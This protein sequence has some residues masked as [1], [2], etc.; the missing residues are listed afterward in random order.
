MSQNRVG[1]QKFA[2]NTVKVAHPVFRQPLYYV[3]DK[4]TPPAR[5]IRVL[6][7]E[8]TRLIAAGEVIS[9][10][11]DVVRELLDNALDAGALKIDIE[12]ERG[13]LGKITV[14]DNGAGIPFDEVKLAPE[15]HA[16]SKLEDVNRVSTL[17]FRGEALW[18]MALAGTLELISRPQKQLG[19]AKL[20]AKGEEITLE[21]ISAPAGT[22][23]SVLE[24]FA[25]YPARREMQAS[26][27]AEYREVVALV[28]RYIL[29]YPNLFW[30]LECDGEIRLQHA[31]SDSRGAVVTVYGTLVGNRMLSL[32]EGKSRF[33][34]PTPSLPISPSPPSL[35]GVISRP[36]LSRPH[37][38]RMHL[39]VNR[40]PVSFPVELERAVLSAY[41]ELLSPGHAPVCVLA[42]ELPPERVNPNVHPSKAQV[43]LA[44]MSELATLLETTI[45]AAL[46]EHPLARPAPELRPVEPMI[47]KNHSSFPDLEPLA[48]YRDLYLLAEGEG[49][50]WLIDVHAAHERNLYEQFEA[51]FQ[52]SESV[53]LE[54]PELLQLTPEQTMKLLERQGEFAA[55]GMA[56]EGFGAGLVRIRSLPAVVIGLSI[57]NLL[58]LILE[59]ALSE[60]E[61]Q[62][63]V[64]SRLA[65]A[66]ALR[67]GQ[68]TLEN[69]VQVLEELRLTR[70]PWSCPHGRPTVLR[71]SERD[72]AHAFGRRGTRDL[73]RGRDVVKGR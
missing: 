63:A 23:A 57:P 65:C 61:P 62:R 60:R 26:Q 33:I 30:K 73:A 58:E 69:G 66:P 4:M 71:L 15:R 54:H 49:D 20:T 35:S 59:G 8:I 32:G 40:R 28:G 18:S 10:P 42:L 3:P 48:I 9:R 52:E 53:E 45:R 22:K 51:A 64:L 72:L 56:L 41:G 38:D 68:V 50:L 12:L 29:H 1:I 27:A 55:W 34:P 70:Q 16:T 39:S 25:N 17:G 46:S 67:A 5:A 19:A 36:E 31:P 13:G 7:P 11:L 43:G 37:R 14:R 44:G 47:Q 21:R 24:L 2:L 6:P